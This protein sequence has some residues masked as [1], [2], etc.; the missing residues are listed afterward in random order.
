MREPNSRASLC[1]GAL[2][3]F[4]SA[5]FNIWFHVFCSGTSRLEGEPCSETPLARC[6]TDGRSNV[7]EVAVVD[8]AWGIGKVGMIQGVQRLRSKLELEAFR[9]RQC[10]ENAHVYVE[11]T[12]S[13]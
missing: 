13:V 3:H 12:R 6:L 9:E 8:A 1:N 2:D 5:A 7:T 10:T 4:S 11:E